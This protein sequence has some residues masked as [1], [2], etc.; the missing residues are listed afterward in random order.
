MAHDASDSDQNEKVYSV[1]HVFGINDLSNPSVMG[2]L[3][4]HLFRECPRE[5]TGHQLSLW[6]SPSH[7]SKHRD[8]ARTG[9][10]QNQYHSVAGSG[11]APIKLAQNSA[12]SLLAICSQVHRHSVSPASPCLLH[13]GPNH[14][15]ITSCLKNLC[16]QGQVHTA[17]FSA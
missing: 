4:P 15:H 6:F 17:E 3:C 12:A 8:W 14:N 9:L 10:E 13:P 7:P 2:L 11:W 5:T 16:S 1:W